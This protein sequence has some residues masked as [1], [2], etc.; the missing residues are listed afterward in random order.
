MDDSRVA[1]ALSYCA[2]TTTKTGDM[3]NAEAVV[4]SS[5]CTI[6]DSVNALPSPRCESDSRDL[7]VERRVSFRN[8]DGLKALEMAARLGVKL[9]STRCATNSLA[10]MFLVISPL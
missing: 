7:R 1:E 4:A 6:V 10:E 5:S 9:T 8:D 2:K 3:E